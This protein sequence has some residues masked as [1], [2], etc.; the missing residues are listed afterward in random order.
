MRHNPDRPPFEAYRGTEPY[1]FIS[2]ARVDSMSVFG[3]LI[4]LR[5]WGANI[6]YDEGIM[7]GSEWPKEIAHAI[8]GCAMFLYFIS[9]RSVES[10]NCRNEIY[11]ALAL[12]KPFFGIYL[13]E[14][15]IDMIDAGLALSIG[16]LQSVMKCRMDEASYETKLHRSL[17]QKISIP[18]GPKL[19]YR[20]GAVELVQPP[21]P[22]IDVPAVNLSPVTPNDEHL[23]LDLTI[24]ERREPAPVTPPPIVLPA[25]VVEPA[26]FSLKIPSS[27]LS[28]GTAGT[29]L[30]L[31]PADPQKGV[32]LHFRTGTAYSIGRSPLEAD[33][34]SVFFPR[35]ELN[36][37]RSKRISKVHARLEFRNNKFLLQCTGRGDVSLGP[38]KVSGE[39]VVSPQAPGSLV[40]AEDYALDLHFD[41]SITTRFQV[42]NCARWY[43]GKF[44]LDIRAIG[45]VRFH[46]SNGGFG[47]RNSCWLFTAVALGSDP[48]SCFQVAPNMPKRQGY[49]VRAGGCFWILNEVDNKKVSI[50][51]VPVDVY[52]LVPL[53]QN[54]K[55]QLGDLQYLVQIS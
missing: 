47:L 25:P 30:R 23:F 43:A 15:Q 26:N 55:V 13:E 29:V 6:W 24:V 38:Q 27:Y 17:S 33:W 28:K 42:T 2:Y 32:E 4:R 21:P 3:E 44:D 8:K 52:E 16:S 53:T 54:D 36:D 19:S 39:V 5:D 20:E 1:I 34:I 10:V 11:Y 31:A 49:L 18:G 40:L 48:N 51:D 9:R 22:F 12:K 7:P 41:R 45:A 35:S 46:T 37:S 14:T 50:N